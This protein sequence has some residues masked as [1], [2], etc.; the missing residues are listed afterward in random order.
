MPSE[1]LANRAIL[2]RQKK[3]TAL[4]NGNLAARAI[5][6][7]FLSLSNGLKRFSDS[8][9]NAEDPRR[10]QNA[11]RNRGCC[12]ATNAEFGQTGGSV[13]YRNFHWNTADT[14][15]N[16]NNNSSAGNKRTQGKTCNFGGRTNYSRYK[17]GFYKC[18]GTSTRRAIHYACTDLPSCN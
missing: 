5:E 11:C 14:T 1:S 16:F 3:E 10:D 18:W 7:D 8:A 17:N 9:W 15:I 4:A 2:C 6:Q 13:S 12:L